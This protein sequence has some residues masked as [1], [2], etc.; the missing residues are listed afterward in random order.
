MAE[1]KVVL[2][3]PV[4][5]GRAGRP[6]KHMLGR[7]RALSGQRLSETCEWSWGAGEREAK[8]SGVQRG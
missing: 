8:R 1:T 2:Y 7:G 3:L 4:G 5:G 6:E